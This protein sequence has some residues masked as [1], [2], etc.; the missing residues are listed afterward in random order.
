MAYISNNQFLTTDELSPASS[1]IVPS[2]IGRISGVE[3]LLASPTTTV[4]IG[5]NG[6]LLRGTVG[7]WVAGGSVLHPVTGA[8]S[9]GRFLFSNGSTSTEYL[10]SLAWPPTITNPIYKATP[11]IRGLSTGYC[12]ILITGFNL[13]PPNNQFTGITMSFPFAIPTVSNIEINGLIPQTPGLTNFSVHQSESDG[14][15]AAGNSPP[16][17]VNYKSTTKFP[18]VN[19]SG[20]Q[21]VVDSLTYNHT[22]VHGHSSATHAYIAG[23]TPPPTVNQFVEKFP[24]QTDSTWVE[25]GDIDKRGAGATISGESHGYVCG[26]LDGNTIKKF[27]FATDS[28]SADFGT[29]IGTVFNSYQYTA[30]LASTAAGYITGGSPPASPTNY[31]SEVTIFPFASDS[32]SSFNRDLHVAY[33]NHAGIAQ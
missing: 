21:S 11:G 13:Q 16:G 22:E 26:G 3:Y 9:V 8:Q 1:S 4:T 30:G 5:T 28:P 33:G 14:Y 27:P 18:L 17:A 15:K 12:G 23:G 24:F 20:K 32:G 6:P 19:L 10:S 25:V 2:N 31:D 7:G 29:T